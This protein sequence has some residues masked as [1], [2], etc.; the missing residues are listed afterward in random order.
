MQI[1]G[2]LAATLVTKVVVPVLY[3]MFVEDL[4]IIRWDPPELLRQQAGPPRHEP[5]ST[6]VLA[7][8]LD[9]A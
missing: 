6:T 8:Q 9:C 5:E 2:L 3:V 1:V 7:P 4:K